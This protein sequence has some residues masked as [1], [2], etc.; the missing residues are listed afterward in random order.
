MRAYDS[1]RREVIIRPIVF[2]VLFQVLKILVSFSLL[3]GRP[4]IHSGGVIPSSFHLKLKFIHDCRVI[5]IPSTGGAHLPY[6]PVLEISHGGD[7]F[8]MTGF[9]FVEVQI[10][11]PTDFIRDPVPM[12]FDMHSSPVILDLMRSMSYM[13]S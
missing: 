7:D 11:E 10:V 9:T 3:L 13:P 8:L 2:Q 4:W 1:T 12:S 6:D 5:T